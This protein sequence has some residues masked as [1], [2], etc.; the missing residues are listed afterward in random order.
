MAA[1]SVQSDIVI[2]VQTTGVDEAVT[3]LDKLATVSET[4]SKATESAARGLRGLAQQDETYRAI[5]KVETAQ[6]RLNLAMA[7]GL[8]DTQEYSA[9]ARVLAQRQEEVARFTGSRGANDNALGL[10][11]MQLLE[12]MH[13]F[14]SLADQMIAGQSAARAL[15]MESGRIGQVLTS[16]QGSAVDTLKAMG[17]ALTSMI[18][19]GRLVGGAIVGSLAG[20]QFAASAAQSALAELGRASEKINLPAS[21]ILGA[22]SVGA[23]AGLSR[24]Q[25]DAALASA[26][27]QFAEYKTNGGEVFDML[28]KIDRGFLSVTDRAR[29]ASEWID[30][31][32]L[33]IKKLPSDQALN[34]AQKLFGADQGK[35]LLDSIRSGAMSMQAIADAASNSGAATNEAAKRA[36][37]ME[38]QIAAAAETADTKLLVAFQSLGSPVES[39]KLSWYGVV[40][41]IGDAIAKS[42]ELQLFLGGMAHPFDAIAN[43]ASGAWSAATGGKTTTTPIG[44]LIPSA[45]SGIVQ[46]QAATAGDD[47]ARAA[48]LNSAAD[49]EKIRQDAAFAAQAKMADTFAQRDAIIVEKARADS[50][51]DSTNAL[52]IAA[53][54]EAERTQNL[55]D[56]ARQ[57]RDLAKSSADRLAMA[58]M[59]AFD[60]AHAEIDNQVRDLRA[61][62]LPADTSPVTVAFNDTAR[63]ATT[64]SDSFVAAAARFDKL[65][66]ATL[67][68]P[69]PALGPSL[70]P[71]APASPALPIFAQAPVDTSNADKAM[72]A[73][74]ATT[75]AANSLTDALVGA[76]AALTKAPGAT[77]SAPIFAGGA[78]FDLSKAAEAIKAIESAGS[79]GYAAIGPKTRTGDRA[80]GAY[81][82]MGDN[83]SAWTSKYAGGAMNA[84]DFLNNPRAQDAVFAGQFT[85]LV[86]K[87]GNLTDAVSAWFTGRPLAEGK[88]RSDGMTTGAQYVTKFQNIYG[89]VTPATPATPTGA[90]PIASRASIESS[91]DKFAAD[92]HA[93]VNV[94]LYDSKIAALTK[95][96]DA[97]ERTLAR[98]TDA[99]GRSD[100]EVL[101]ASKAQEIYNQF[102]AQGV[103]LGPEQVAAI[104]AVAGRY[105]DLTKRTKEAADANAEYIKGMDS[106]RGLATNSVTSLAQGLIQG[107]KPK[108]LLKGILSNVENAGISNSVNFLSDKIFD[109]QGTTGAGTVGGDL[110]ASANSFGKSLLSSISDA[111]GFGNGKAANAQQM[112]VNATTVNVS[113]ATA[114]LAGLGGSGGG[115]TGGFFQSIGSAIGSFFNS[116]P[117]PT[118]G[119][120]GSLAVPTFAEG[121]VMG[122]SGPIPMRAYAGGG[123]AHTP[124]LALFG[125]GSGP[126][127]FVPLKGGAIPVQ[128]NGNG[129]GT[130]VSVHNYAGVDIEPR[131][132]AG[133]VELIVGKRVAQ[134]MAQVPTMMQDYQRRTA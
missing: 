23:G 74:G 131:V 2:A 88:N 87:F 63:A 123:V 65:S 44:R 56:S 12:S 127:A 52:K 42:K 55:V 110:F 93:A 16:G 30:A 118:V 117:T 106:V 13:I 66:S 107:Q 114:G 24:D 46:P 103:K 89:G 98:Q 70:Q 113:G 96:L 33:E 132:T 90:A 124:Q 105:A 28:S 40:G 77:G 108:D 75:R 134:A 109:K 39:L 130:S 104:D 4:T 43:A 59:S 81:Q 11:N 47:R 14:K 79:G 26:T 100:E 86:N 15:A 18:T 116:G 125:E 51:R 111:L 49:A 122:P 54:A 64:L 57:A 10:N 22:R 120:A 129:G 67:A 80:F 83:L 48:Y 60:R 45:D 72:T 85:T 53:T 21:S 94:E 91:I 3:N 95:D 78:S 68:P 119:G 69:T 61:K 31:V 121:G 62:L 37:E 102:A 8:T 58:G 25:T 34:L 101:K 50:L 76:A 115:G 99:L 7:Q 36:A 29:G 19:P 71:I 35:L 73:F 128:M 5:Q 84:Q 32:I 92:S 6:R 112:N 126:E 27:N 97:Q 17:S 133:H 20:I 1:E 41:G 9:A 82:V 38:K